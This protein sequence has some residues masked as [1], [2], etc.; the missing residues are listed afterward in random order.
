MILVSSVGTGAG[1]WKEVTSL[2]RWGGRRRASGRE[3][4][5][6]ICRDRSVCSPQELEVL[7]W[8][9]HCL[10]TQRVIRYWK[11]SWTQREI[12]IFLVWQKFPSHYSHFSLIFHHLVQVLVLTGLLLDPPSSAEVGSSWER[13]VFSN[14]P[15]SLWSPIHL[16][17]PEGS[18]FQKRLPLVP[19]KREQ[20]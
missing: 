11:F 4:P 20:E 18:I 17:V 1:G 10:P 7:V 5:H 9:Q 6:G 12:T 8:G 19:W 15:L 3:G 2:G 14:L 13:V 16:W